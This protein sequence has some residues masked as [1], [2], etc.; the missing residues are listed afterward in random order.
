MKKLPFIVFFLFSLIGRGQETHSVEELQKVF[1]TAVLKSSLVNEF[2]GSVLNVSE[3]SIT[4]VSAIYS[5]PSLV[6]EIEILEFSYSKGMFNEYLEKV[7]S[8]KNNKNV[9][10]Y[11]KQVKW[12]GKRGFVEVNEEEKYCSLILNWDKKYV[13]NIRINGQ[14]GEE[15]LEAVYR[16]LDFSLWNE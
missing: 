7:K 8:T 6:I 12:D 2:T 1:P 11:T 16:S 15:E 14:A 13:L 3:E 4:H 9:Q 5:N 10:G